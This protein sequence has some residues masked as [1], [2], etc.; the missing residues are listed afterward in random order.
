MLIRFSIISVCHFIDALF[1][2]FR[3]LEYTFTNQNEKT[4]FR[5]RITKY[6]GHRVDLSDGTS[7]NK[8]DCL[9][10]IHLHNVRILKEALSLRHPLQRSLAIYRMV[11]QSMPSLAMY[12]DNHPK[13]T[14]IKGI[15]GITMINRGVT[16]LG[17]EKFLPNSR[18]YKLFKFCTQFPIFLLATTSI[19]MRNIKKQCPT[20]LFMS[21]EKL[22][23]KYLDTRQA[24]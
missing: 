14:Q 6:K 22:F 2:Y 24:T 9:L 10:K 20:Y 23:E 7:I 15:V 4:I 16:H 18:F 5:V 1:L 17:F 3:R 12:I 8:N 13:S 11:E 21:K 19:S